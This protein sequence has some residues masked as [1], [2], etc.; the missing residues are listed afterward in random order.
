MRQ[1]SPEHLVARLRA[2]CEDQLVSVIL[3]GSAAAGDFI[4]G[5]SDLNILIVVKDTSRSTLKQISVAC[6]GWLRAGHP[7]PMVFSRTE[8]ERAVDVFPIEFLDM[9]LARRVLHGDDVVGSLAI[10]Y[11]SYRLQLEHELRSKMVELRERYLVVS[12]N[13]RRVRRLMQQ[14]LSTFLA[15]GRAALR[16]FTREVPASKLEAVR[17]LRAYVAFDLDVLE[18][19]HRLKQG[20]E[21]GRGQVEECFERYLAAVNELIHHVDATAEREPKE[22]MPA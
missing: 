9:K 22:A 14:S 2:V 1:T 10:R 17:Q 20:K 3:Y 19:V 12:E 15:L 7:A 11:Q 6:R 16:L 5:H 18:Q 21:R 13:P 8:L 4:A